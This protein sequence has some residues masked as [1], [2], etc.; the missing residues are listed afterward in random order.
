MLLDY[1]TDRLHESVSD[2][3]FVTDRALILFIEVV[4]CVRLCKIMPAQRTFE[5]GSQ[6]KAPP[7]ACAMKGMPALQRSDELSP[8]QDL[9]ANGTFYGI[10]GLR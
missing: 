9:F 2:D 10:C 8:L 7:N 1:L 5:I 6:Y 4:S 3:A